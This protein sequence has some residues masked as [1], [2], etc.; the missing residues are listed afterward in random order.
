MISGIPYFSGYVNYELTIEL[1]AAIE[2][3]VLPRGWQ[4]LID[5]LDE[6]SPAFFFDLIRPTKDSISLLEIVEK[7]LFWAIAHKSLEKQH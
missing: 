3:D 4:H 2:I 6:F 5:G 1:T 7:L